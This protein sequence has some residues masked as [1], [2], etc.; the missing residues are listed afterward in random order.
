MLPKTST[1]LF[2]S[3][4]PPR[5]FLTAFTTGCTTTHPSQQTVT[6]TKVQ[7]KEEHCA[8]QAYEQALRSTAR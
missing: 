6:T 1:W 3:V 7:T 8:D 2:P 4:S 5:Y